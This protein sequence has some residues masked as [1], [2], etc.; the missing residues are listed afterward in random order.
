MKMMRSTRRISISGVTFIFGSVFDI[1]DKHLLFLQT[2]AQEKS[3]Q[4]LI[5][6]IPAKKPECEAKILIAQKLKLR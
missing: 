4:R 5:R 2:P 6:K 1:D 3:S